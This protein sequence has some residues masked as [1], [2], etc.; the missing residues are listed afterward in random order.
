MTLVRKETK[1]GHSYTLDGKAVQGVTTILN[2]GLPKPQLVYWS[3][4][5]VA[6]Y[7]ADNFD[8]VNELRSMGREPMIAALKATPWESRD[9]AAARGTDVH[10]LAEA[11]MH[12]QEV[13][14]PRELR[15]YVT[16]YVDMIDAWQIT[17]VL[18][19]K[20][21]GNRDWWYAGTFDAIVDIGAGP[22]AGQRMLLDWKTSKGVYPET[23]CQL[24]AYQ[25]AEFYIDD[26]GAEQPMPEVDALGVVHVQNGV[27]E[28]CAVNDPGKAWQQFQ[29]V[30]ILARTLDDL[31]TQ[32]AE[33]VGVGVHV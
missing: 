28:L 3:A 31:K 1:R 10:A 29:D 16:G 12:D 20:V 7:V 30:L 4:K 27:S 6:E 25:N 26:D 18:T 2:K 24:A 17:P 15:G 8:T 5:T 32:I 22:F 33:P 13:E 14:V 19:E 21:I 11:I 9:R 23:A